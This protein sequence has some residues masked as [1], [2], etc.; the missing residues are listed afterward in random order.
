MG[1]NKNNNCISKYE[2]TQE[3]EKKYSKEGKNQ[4]N[5]TQNLL[6]PVGIPNNNTPTPR[7]VCNDDDDA[8]PTLQMMMIMINGG[9]GVV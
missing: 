5:C 1:E 7:V 2:V 8:K 9:F 6:L 3:G 4:S